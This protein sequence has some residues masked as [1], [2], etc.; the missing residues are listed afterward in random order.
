MAVRKFNYKR[1]VK[2]IN[3]DCIVEATYVDTKDRM[4]VVMTVENAI[5]MLNEAIEQATDITQYWRELNIKEENNIVK[6]IVAIN[7][8]KDGYKFL[9]EMQ[10]MFAQ[11]NGY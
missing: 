4:I 5:E 6:K 9:T 2:F 3:S 7:D 8:L 11:K 10:K 1:F